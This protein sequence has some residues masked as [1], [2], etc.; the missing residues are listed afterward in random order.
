MTELRV[1][2]IGAG[3][4]GSGIAQTLAVAGYETVCCDVARRGARARAASTWSSGRFGVDGAV[5]R[6]KLTR[7]PWPTPRSRD[8]PGRARSRWRRRPT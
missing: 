7:A 6:G 4:M 2:V 1:G 8:S 5:A 3:V